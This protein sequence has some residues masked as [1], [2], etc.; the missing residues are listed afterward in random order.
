MDINPFGNRPDEWALYD[1]LVGKTMLELGGKQ[2]P[3][4]IKGEHLTYKAYFESLGFKHISID[5]N[6]LWGAIK[7]DLRNPLWDEFGQ[8]SMVTNFGTTEH[9]DGQ[10]GVW[11]NIHHLV[12]PGGVYIGQT[13]YHDGRSWW[14]HGEHYPT[15]EF[16]ESFCELNGWTLERMY[17]DREVPFENLYVRMYKPGPGVFTMPDSSLIKRNIRRKR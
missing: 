2:N 9:V 4:L 11:E 8:F 6:G 13:P 5:W 14:W 3:D 15:E 16:F 7:R 17:V 1:P 12:E 10:R